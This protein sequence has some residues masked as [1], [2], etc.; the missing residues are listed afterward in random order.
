M[1]LLSKHLLVQ[2]QQWK[3][4]ID[5]VLVFLLLTVNI[6]HT[7]FRCFYCWI[8]TSKCCPSRVNF[9]ILIS[10]LSGIIKLTTSVFH[11]ELLILFSFIQ[12]SSKLS[13][14]R[15][16]NLSFIKIQPSPYYAFPFAASSNNNLA[17]F[18]V[19]QTKKANS[20]IC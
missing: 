9:S 4:V 1:A 8:W 18:L 7:F 17:I 5:V 6:F 2:S 11:S 15:I 12:V 13:P 10:F 20:D 3:Q 19:K 16:S 14:Q